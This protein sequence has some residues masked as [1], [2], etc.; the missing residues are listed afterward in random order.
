MWCVAGRSRPRRAARVL[1]PLP[2]HVSLVLTNLSRVLLL[3]L[4]NLG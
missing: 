3:K 1:L 2:F 4:P